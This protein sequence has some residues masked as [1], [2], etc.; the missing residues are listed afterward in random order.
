MRVFCGD[1]H[2]YPA[3]RGTDRRP[4]CWLDRRAALVRLS[5]VQSLGDRMDMGDQ[6][7]HAA[8]RTPLLV[9]AAPGAGHRSSLLAEVRPALGVYA[10]GQPFT[11]DAAR[12]LYLLACRSP[13]S[14]S[15][16]LAEARALRHCGLRADDQPV[17]DPQPHRLWT[18][19]LPAYQLCLRIRHGKPA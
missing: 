13:F 3:H 17:A 16:R 18:M 15:P 5:L 2:S 14:R 1:L 6:P 8:L 7:F 19:D 10:F 12:R 4:P 9:R 11:A